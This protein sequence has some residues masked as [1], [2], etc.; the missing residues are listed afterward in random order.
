M[1]EFIKRLGNYKKTIISFLIVILAFV[2]ILL[3]ETI[4]LDSVSKIKMTLNGESKVEI[5]L[6]QTYQDLKASAQFRKKDI[7]NDIKITSN[8]DTSKIGE[9]YIL[10]QV[11][12]KNKTESLKRSITVVDKEAPI[13]TLNGDDK[14]ELEEG[15]N[16]TDPFVTAIDNYDG[17]ITQKVT[18]EGT[19]DTNTIGT[20]TI[21]YHAKDSSN[22][23][24]VATRTVEIIKRKIVYKPG[25]AV[26]NYH[27]FYSDGEV[28]G[29][30]ICLNTNKFEE[31]LKYLKD[32]NY[33]TL[34][35]QE[36]VDW[37]YGR[38]ELPKKSVLLTIDD[39]ALG[40]GIH[41]GN[42]LIPLLEKYQVHATLFLITGWWD[43][44]NY[45]SN[46]LDIESHTNDM[47][48]EGFCSGVTRGA[49]MLCSSHDV[50]L[51]DLK[52]SIEI[53]GS[54]KA[55]CYPFYAYNDA[56]IQVVKEAGFEVA[57][58]GGGYKATRNSNK[59]AVPRFPIQSSITLDTF[60]SYIS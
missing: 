46:Y 45:R 21:T 3:Y 27:F 47:H 16:F 41:N 33:K 29:Q 56:A 28:C 11:K 44:N 23:E 58:A 43:I 26:L 6:N 25:I 60:I 13:I 14:I 52:K 51:T 30:S 5:E 17:D 22:N 31:Q 54:K 2:L 55:F 37:I 48:N 39:G 42:K 59:Y 8:L 20:Y 4:Y 57:F 1:G 34:T 36:F 10:Y 50:A 32:N 40:T 18:M 24:S 38:I 7:T 53:T 49:R 12:Y 15:S 35:M 19:V 9:Y